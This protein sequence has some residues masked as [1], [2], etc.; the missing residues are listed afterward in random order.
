[1]QVQKSN[2]TVGWRKN[3]LSRAIKHEISFIQHRMSCGCNLLEAGRGC[4]GSIALSLLQ[5]CWKYIGIARCEKMRWDTH[6]YA[7]YGFCFSCRTAWC[8]ALPAKPRTPWPVVRFHICYVP[9]QC[10]VPLPIFSG[11]C[12][13]LN[14][15]W[16][17]SA[18]DQVKV[19]VLRA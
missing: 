7:L 2:R 8:K 12:I 9:K 1:M 17:W 19:A 5:F 15:A 16:S 11:V 14:P 18:L 13:A 10:Q 4:W 6:F 3:S